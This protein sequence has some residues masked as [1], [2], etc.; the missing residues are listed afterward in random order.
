[1]KFIKYPKIPYLESEKELEGKEVYLFEKLDGSNCQIRKENWRVF[2]AKRSGDVLE[3]EWENKKEKKWIENFYKWAMSNSS[4]L[5]LPEG[6]IFYGEWLHKKSFGNGVIYPE[7]C[8][9]RFYLIDCIKTK[10]NENFE[11]L[12]YEEGEKI[13]KE[14]SIEE[15]RILPYTKIFSPSLNELKKKIFGGLE[16]QIAEGI[17]EGI[18]I[19]DYSVNPPFMRKIVSE[20]YEEK[21]ERIK[22]ERKKY[23]T[24]SR[25]KKAYEKAIEEEEKVSQQRIIEII[26]KDI[27]EETNIDADVEYAKQRILNFLDMINLKIPP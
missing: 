25:I 22:D 13:I 21:D 5:N 4:L 26:I 11:F 6:I 10:E 15:V 2:A 12:P 3:K 19:K 23:I 27:K 7:D 20:P 18:V 1:M 24:L 14:R 16:K 9:D 8:Y 17:P